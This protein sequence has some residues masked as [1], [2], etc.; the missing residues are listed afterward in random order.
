PVPS[1]PRESLTASRRAPEDRVT[2]D[3]PIPTRIRRGAS[4]R[5]TGHA[6]VVGGD[7]LQHGFRSAAIRGD[8]KLDLVPASTCAGA[9]TSAGVARP[10]ECCDSGARAKLPA[11]RTELGLRLPLAR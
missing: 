10:A 7:L 4:C 2:S 8:S 3:A 1:W 5:A 6:P 11:P 9:E